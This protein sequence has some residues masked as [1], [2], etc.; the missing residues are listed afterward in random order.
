MYAK[1]GSNIVQ[2]GKET[3]TIKLQL[4]LNQITTFLLFT[5]A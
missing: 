1:I 3:C 5:N 4:D 2:M